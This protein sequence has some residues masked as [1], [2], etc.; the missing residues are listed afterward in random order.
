[1]NTHLY[2]Y[3]YEPMFDAPTRLTLF[4]QYNVQDSILVCMTQPYLPIFTEA[5]NIEDSI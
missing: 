5:E 2:S 3:T 4:V 1:M